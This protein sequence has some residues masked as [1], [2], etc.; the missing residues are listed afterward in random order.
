[1]DSHTTR[2]PRAAAVV[3][4]VVVAGVCAGPPAAAAYVGGGAFALRSSVNALAVPLSVG[5][6]PAVNLPPDGGGPYS[7]SVTTTNVLGLAPV[8]VASVTTRGN[9]GLGSVSSS[10]SLEDAA[11]AGIVTVTSA[12]SGCVAS[13]NGASGSATVA[14]LTVAG[15]P[16]STA[17]AGA[18]TTFSLPVGR[19]VINEQRRDGATGVTVNA[20]HVVF[21]AGVLSGDVVIGQSR[22]SVTSSA[23]KRA[24]ALRHAR[25]VKAR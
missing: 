7:A 17:D 9:S 14:G 10:A 23:R 6:L 13:E 11:V 8:R 24:M 19:V 15:I 4:T 25:K 20:L 16:V 21:D 18:D 2:K 3:A 1:M 12:R 22:C 5:A